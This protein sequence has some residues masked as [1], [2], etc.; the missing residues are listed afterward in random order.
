M[1]IARGILL[2]GSLAALAACHGGPK[3]EAQKVGVRDDTLV[4][5]DEDYFHEM[6]DGVTLTPDEVKGRNM[7][8]VWSGG[9]DRFWDTMSK[10]T[11]GGF[12]LLKIVAPPPGSP[13]A[14]PT[15]WKVM[16]LVNEPCFSAPT[17]PDG[18]GLWRDTRD[19]GCAPDPFANEK[20]YPGIRIGARG[21]TV[22]VGSYFGEPSG[23]L[24]L[25]LFPNPDFDEKAKARWDAKRYYSDAR[26]Y[27]DPRLVRPYRVG[28][29]CGFCHLGPS[30]TRPPA[31]P[32]KPAFANLN[33]TVGA[34]YMWVDRLFMWKADPSNYMYQLVSTY[35]PGAMDTSLVSTDNINNPRTMNAVYLLGDRLGAAR[36]FGRETLAGGSTKNVQ[37]NDILDS[38]PLTQYFA[39]PATVWTPHVLKDGADAVGAL[40]ALNRVYLNIG[41]FSEEWLTHFNPVVGGKI[42]S[43]IEIATARRNSAYWRATEAGTPLTALFFLKAARPDPLANAPGGAGYLKASPQVLQRGAMAFANTCAR[44]HSSKQPDAPAG[45]SLVDAIGP[46]YLTR[47][48]AWWRWTQSEDFKGRMRA[49]VARP[50]FRQGNYFSTDA[51]IPVT[52][53]RTNLCS[54]LATNALRG[55]I[56]DNFSSESYKVLPSVGTVAYQDPFTGEARAYR[57]PAGGRGYTRV[58]SLV[59]LWSTA[60]FLLANTVGTFNGDPS[61]AGRMAAF[62]DGIA[63]M[64]WPNLRERDAMLPGAWGMIDRTTTRSKLYVPSSFIPDAPGPLDEQARKA[65]RTLENADG[66]IELR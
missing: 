65:L 13:N 1:V 33:S 50:D 54:P 21:T 14:R 16:G 9:N 28:M 59:S 37:F 17:N 27:N 41:L 46:D 4:Q 29:S 31:D 3:D 19:P 30:P 35:R 58:P 62:D 64:L 43:P 5:A 44:C 55:N 49:L 60:P 23:I 34:Q 15:R 36:K 47:F 7:W 2:S 6:D 18:Y 38:G 25:R 48:K 51:R 66:D 8:L 20:K 45:A 63:K 53:L 56:W 26:Y 24:G 22:P 57:M 32:E 52:L 39:K 61:V 40:G 10:P 42:I 11:L 12:D